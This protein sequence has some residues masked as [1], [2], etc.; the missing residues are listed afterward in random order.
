MHDK[1]IF[2]ASIFFIIVSDSCQFCF[3]S[4]DLIF[5]SLESWI[6]GKRFLKKFKFLDAMLLAFAKAFPASNWWWC[7]SQT[8]QRR[9]RTQLY[10]TEC[11]AG[12]R[13]TYCCLPSEPHPVLLPAVEIKGRGHDISWKWASI[14]KIFHTL[15]PLP[16]LLK[17]ANFIP[18][19]WQPPPAMG[20]ATPLRQL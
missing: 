7:G 19:A 20:L 9:Q 18:W 5:I 16:I 14:Y 2:R 4:D 15:L 10:P 8:P 3:Y 11:E 1:N 6:T 13:L 17:G 12:F